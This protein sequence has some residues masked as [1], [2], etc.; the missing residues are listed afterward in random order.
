M[1]MVICQKG[2]QVME[3][4]AFKIEIR[5]KPKIANWMFLLRFA[6]NFYLVHYND[7]YGLISILGTIK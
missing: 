7:L 1:K 3:L 6:H 2:K 5:S 4:C